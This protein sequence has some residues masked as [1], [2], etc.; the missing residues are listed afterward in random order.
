MEY[1][2][3]CFIPLLFAVWT[4]I[5]SL[6]NNT[7]GNPSTNIRVAVKSLELLSDLN[8]FSGLLLQGLKQCSSKM[9]VF[10]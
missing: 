6:I 8:R 3:S 4:L 9:S 7:M 1:M 2:H 5:P 10:F